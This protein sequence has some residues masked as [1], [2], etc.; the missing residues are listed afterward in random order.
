MA[1]KTNCAKRTRFEEAARGR[2]ER[3]TARRS[4]GL[5]LQTP[6]ERWDIQD[7]DRTSLVNMQEESWQAVNS[8]RRLMPAMIICQDLLPDPNGARLSSFAIVFTVG[9]FLVDMTRS[10]E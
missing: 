9:Y 1:A 7:N 8:A 3:L 10:I 6:L 2:S 5:N 4:F